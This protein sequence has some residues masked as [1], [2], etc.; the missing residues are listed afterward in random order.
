[1]AAVPRFVLATANPHKV[2]EIAAILEGLAELLP[3]PD[4]VQEVEENAP[5]LVGNARLKAVA[6]ATATGDAALAD[7]T[8]L[9]IDA[10]D[11]EPGVRSARFAGEP[12]RDSANRAL[13]LERLQGLGESARS[14]RFRTVIVTVDPDGSER[15]CEGVVEGHIIDSERGEGGFGYDSIFVPNDGDGRTFAEMSGEEK[16]EISHRGRALRSLAKVL[17]EEQTN[18]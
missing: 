1:M 8:G 3:R 14:A 5:T 2:D 9:E 16:N 18:A 13:V 12:P 17:A 15:V 4:S 10:L 6:I 7:D 11:G